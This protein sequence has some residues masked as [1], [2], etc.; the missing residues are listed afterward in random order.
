M[1]AYRLKADIPFSDWHFALVPI[2]DSMCSP[3]GNPLKSLDEFT[4]LAGLFIQFGS[5]IDHLFDKPCIWFDI[6]FDNGPAELTGKR[7]LTYEPTEDYLRALATLQAFAME[8][9]MKLIE[10][11]YNGLNHDHSNRPC[12]PSSQHKAGESALGS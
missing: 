10:P 5:C 6:K 8:R 3:V 4:A 12:T 11:T 7:S 2:A 9:N 1:A